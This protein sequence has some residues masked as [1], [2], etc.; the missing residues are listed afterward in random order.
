MTTKKIR[1][2]RELTFIVAAVLILALLLGVS[3][4]IISFLFT[5]LSRALGNDGIR[6]AP[7]VT[8]NLEKF[9]QV[10]QGLNQK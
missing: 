5:N 6:P 9:R 10:L 8:F 3:T 7:A 4:Y 1:H 2:S